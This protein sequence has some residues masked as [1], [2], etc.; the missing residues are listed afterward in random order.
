MYHT[1]IST[2]AVYSCVMIKKGFHSP[3]KVNHYGMCSCS[4]IPRKKVVKMR[5]L[6]NPKSNVS[7]SIIMWEFKGVCLQYVLTCDSVNRSNSWGS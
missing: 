1:C 4:L 2:V 5:I 7:F 3:H 6:R